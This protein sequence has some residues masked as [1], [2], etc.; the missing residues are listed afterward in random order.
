MSF[1]MNGV[2]IIQANNE[3]SENMIYNR[4]EMRV[5]TAQRYTETNRKPNT[6]G[7]GGI[8]VARLEEHGR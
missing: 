4:D 7:D 3:L 1:M 2:F 8:A 6:G 5:K